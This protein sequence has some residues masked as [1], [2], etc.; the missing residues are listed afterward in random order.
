MTLK[1]SLFCTINT[2]A[3]I[4]VYLT[5]GV[6]KLTNYKRLKNSIFSMNINLKYITAKFHLLST[7][8]KSAI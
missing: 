2:S 5:L 1:L 8:K 6:N 7:T 4:K 3:V